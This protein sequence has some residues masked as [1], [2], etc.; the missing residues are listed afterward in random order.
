MVKAEALLINKLGLHARP[1][2]KIVKIAG[3]SQS[4]VTLTYNGQR[5]NGRS[6]LGV[7]LLQAYQGSKISIEARGEDEEEVLRLIL[8]LVANKFEED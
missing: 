3:N 2:N 4:E 7:I 6:I 8:E 5:A 1:A